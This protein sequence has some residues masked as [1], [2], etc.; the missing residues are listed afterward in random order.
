VAQDAGQFLFDK[1]RVTVLLDMELA[2]ITD[3]MIDIAALR[4]RA[5]AE[6]MGDLRPL[7]R[8]YVERTCRPLDRQRISFLTA[9]WQAGVCATIVYSLHNPKPVTNYPEYLSWYLNCMALALQAIA[10]YDRYELEDEKGGPERAPS[11]W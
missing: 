9:S 8:R 10:E 2:R 3:P 6:P 11:R 1:G 4:P 7:L 5:L